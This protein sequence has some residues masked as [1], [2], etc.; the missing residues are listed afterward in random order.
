MCDQFFWPTGLMITLSFMSVSSEDRSKGEGTRWSPCESGRRPLLPSLFYVEVFSTGYG[1]QLWE[2]Q[3][4]GGWGKRMTQ[5][6]RPT[7][8]TKG[9]PISPNQTTATKESARIFM[10]NTKKFRCKLGDCIKAAARSTQTPH[11][12]ENTGQKR[13]LFS[14][15]SLNLQ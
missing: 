5:S 1:G 10:S 4:L 15:F 2:S 11:S 14:W 8:V 6:L 9:D 7:L 3:R 12:I 13:G